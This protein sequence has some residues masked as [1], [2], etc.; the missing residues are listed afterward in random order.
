MPRPKVFISSTFRDLQ[1]TREEL[2]EFISD[3]DF[4]PVAFEFGDIAFEPSKHLEE[5][6]YA[7]IPECS[8]LIL[9]IKNN[10]GSTSERRP[11]LGASEEKMYSI[12]SNEYKVALDH[13]IPVFVFINQSTHDEYV[14]YTKQNRPGNFVF[15]HIDNPKIAKFID[16]LHRDNSTRYIFKYN[17]HGDIKRILRKQWSGLFNRYLEN[18]RKH[19]LRLKQEVAIN[20]YKF[21]YLRHKQ[22]LSQQ[23]ISKRSNLKQGLVIRIEDAALRVKRLSSDDFVRVSFDEAS[24]LANALSCSVGNIRSGL[25]DEFL[26]QFIVYY[27]HNKGSIHAKSSVSKSRSVF[28]TKA[29]FLDFDGTMTYHLNKST[30]WELI[31]LE[32]GYADTDC[33]DLHRRFSNHEISHADWCRI[34]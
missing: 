24:R 2:S 26:S 34:T 20:P 32:L 29:V 11:S 4:E 33:S 17:S 27:S 12:T 31:W 19:S 10:Y 18:E 28:P 25:P 15:T 3:M 14:S 5:S 21:F 9:V 7:A 30:S 8:M 22:G 16:L 6:C 23:Q 1:Q 13:G